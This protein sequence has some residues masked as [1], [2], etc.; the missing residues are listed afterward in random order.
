MSTAQELQCV[1]HTRKVVFESA[2]I[3]VV[4]FRCLAHG[5]LE[6][7]EEP[8]PTHSIV[9]V[10]RGVFQ[11]RDRCQTLIA[12]PNHILFFNA[13]QPYRY[14]H[15]VPGGDDCTILAVS[16]SLALE[17]VA[18]YAPWDAERPETPF[19]VGFGIGSPRAAQLHYELLALVGRTA[20]HL[21][22]EDVLA[23]LAD[24]AVR[25]AYETRSRQR[26]EE[27][28]HGRAW[29]ECRDMVEAAKLVINQHFE[30]PPSLLDLARTFGCSSFHFSRSFHRA[31]GL[32]LRRYLGRLRACIAADRL[33]GG[34]PDLTE[35]AL[36]LGYSD[37]SHFTNAFRHEWGLS[38]SQFRARHHSQ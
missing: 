4:D 10:R 19:R 37:H 8:N 18:R 13:A 29:R 35:L 34:A 6:G 1:A 7:P 30:S 38:P 33:A 24:E 23:E 5:K 16:T 26:R 15:P 17:L 2:G 32:S 28:L 3:S 36:D 11:R 21:E 20:T 14:S 22:F 12:D 25:T 9:M 27:S 31:A